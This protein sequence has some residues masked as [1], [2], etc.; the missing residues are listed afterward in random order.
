M[1][2]LEIAKSDI[3]ILRGA[4]V[5]LEHIG[6]K[7]TAGQLYNLINLAHSSLHI[8]LRMPEDN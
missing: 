3:P 4:L 1:A 5:A 8:E 6:W 7:R 2:R